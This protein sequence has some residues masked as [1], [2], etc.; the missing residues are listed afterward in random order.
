MT[1]ATSVSNMPDIVAYFAYVVILVIGS[2]ICF[3]VYRP[4]FRRFG[5][6]GWCALPM[7]VVWGVAIAWAGKLLPLMGHAWVFEYVDSEQMYYTVW[8]V[9]LAYLSY[10]YNGY[11]SEDDGFVGPTDILMAVLSIPIGGLVST[12]IWLAVT[13]GKTEKQRESRH[14]ISVSLRLFHFGTL[15]AI[16]ILVWITF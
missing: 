7:A 8:G 11:K 3:A 4:F 2:G 5:Y 10:F 9:G 6:S 13:R 1:D 12:G 15:I 16:P 14:R